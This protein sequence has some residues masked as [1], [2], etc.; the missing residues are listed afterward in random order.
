MPGRS[1]AA[2]SA[3]PGRLLRRTGLDLSTLQAEKGVETLPGI[4]R[5]GNRSGGQRQRRPQ[6]GGPGPA[7]AKCPR[8]LP[9]IAFRLLPVPGAGQWRHSGD[10]D[11]GTEQGRPC[12]LQWLIMPCASSLCTHYEK[13]KENGTHRRPVPEVPTGDSLPRRRATFLGRRVAFRHPLRPPGIVHQ[14]HLWRMRL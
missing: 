5:R 1:R 7:P 14:L 2:P 11:R 4:G 12:R 3:P 6:C 8:P 10:P 13:V 9:P